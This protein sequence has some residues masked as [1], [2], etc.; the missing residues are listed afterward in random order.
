MQIISCSTLNAAII[1]N[2]VKKCLFAF[3]YVGDTNVTNC[4][5]RSHAYIPRSTTSVLLNLWLW[6][7]HDI[8]DGNKKNRSKNT[9]LNTHTATHTDFTRTAG[10]E[11]L[12]SNKSESEILVFF[13]FKWYWHYYQR[14]QSL[15]FSKQTRKTFLSALQWSSYKFQLTFCTNNDGRFNSYS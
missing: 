4:I 13:K 12:C 14:L 8:C 6:A 3:L 11:T 7:A 2:M 15:P 10:D 1:S 5:S 9:L